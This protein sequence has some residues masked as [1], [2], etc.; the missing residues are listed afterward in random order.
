M[1]NDTLAMEII[2]DMKNS[3]EEASEKAME[4]CMILKKAAPDDGKK[5]KKYYEMDREECIKAINDILE[6]TSEVWIIFEIYC[7]SVNMTKEE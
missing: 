7:F 2:R 3:M 6:K 5:D 4:A 1:S